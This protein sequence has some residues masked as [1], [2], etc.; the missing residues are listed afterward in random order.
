MNQKSDQYQVGFLCKQRQCYVA[1]F[2]LT[3]ILACSW[4]A[5]GCLNPVGRELVGKSIEIEKISSADF[6]KNLT[7]HE[8]SE[9]WKQTLN[10]LKQEQKDRP[11]L[12]SRQNIAVAMLH[13]GQIKEAIQILEQIEKEDPGFYYTA[14][15]LGTAYEL[16]GD[17][18]KALKW[19]S[20]GVNRNKDSHYATEWLHVKILEA[21]IALEKDPDWLQK[22]SVLGVD[23]ESENISGQQI[24]AVDHFGQQRNLSQIETALVYQLHERLEFIKPKE[25]VV[26]DLL[27]DLSRVFS[28]TRTQEHSDAVRDLALTYGS[29][30]RPD[31]SKKKSDET[32]SDDTSRNQ[33]FL[34][35]SGLIVGGL[36]CLL[37]LYF[38]KR[39]SI[40]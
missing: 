1:F 12:E 24:A 38:I 31:A 14:A 32:V 19:I 11:F 30:H 36:V 6:L 10:E 3:I 4:D 23:F 9:Y 22:H 28:L 20:E 26:A 7:T 15:N 34:V 25:G 8:G 5:F 17:N 2:L 16:N 18:Q 33:N 39:R 35:Y 29:D 37:G 27:F 21:K 13:L 40:R